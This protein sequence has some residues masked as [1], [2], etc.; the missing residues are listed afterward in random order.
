MKHKG[1]YACYKVCVLWLL[2]VCMCVLGIKN[3]FVNLGHWSGPLSGRISRLHEWPSFSQQAF[4]CIRESG[5]RGIVALCVEFDC[6]KV[7]VAHVYAT[8]HQQ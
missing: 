6:L 3:C 4:T 7:K 1:I 2:C 5:W 8:S